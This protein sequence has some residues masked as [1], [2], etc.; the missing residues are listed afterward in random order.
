[1]QDDDF[2]WDDAKARANYRL[3]GVRFEAARG[4]FNDLSALDRHDDRED[5]GEA[6][7]V[8]IGVVAGRLLSGPTP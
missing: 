2:E 8:T 6:R 1:M 3:H 4:V 7:Y 5:Y